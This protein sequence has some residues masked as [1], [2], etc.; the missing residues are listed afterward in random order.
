MGYKII[1]TTDV[2]GNLFSRSFVDGKP[3]PYGAARLST[4][5]QSRRAQ[6]EVVYVDNG[7][8][9]QGT[10]L[11]SF[12]NKNLETA[13][14]AQLWNYLQ[15]DAYNLGNHDFNY[16]PNFLARF[17][18]ACKMPGVCCNVRYKSQALGAPIVK[19]LG[20]KKIGFIGVVTDYI[21]HWEQP[22]NLLDLEVMPVLS[23]VREQVDKLKEQVDHIVVMYHGGLEADPD[24]GNPTE[25]LTGENV[26][27]QLCKEFPEIDLLISG[28]QHRS[29]VAQ[30]GNTV[31]TQCADKASQCVEIDFDPTVPSGANPFTAELI[32]LADY[33]VD[34]CIE[35]HFEDLWVQTNQWLDTPIGKANW[36]DAKI[37]DIVEAQKQKHP[38]ATF[39]NQVQMAVTGADISACCMFEVMPGW[40]ENLSYR[41]VILNYPF[42]NTLV[43]K[44][45]TGKE[46]LAYMNKIATYWVLKDGK[47]TVADK[48]LYPKR[49]IYNYDL[50]DGVQ[51]T[52]VVTEDASYVENVLYQGQ[53]LQL[54]KKYTLAVN[55]YRAVGGGGFAEFLEM[56]TIYED[57][58]DM[59]EIIIEYI[60]EQTKQGKLL[61]VPEKSNCILRVKQN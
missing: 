18:E 42:P 19:N 53:S 13:V 15:V 33:G 21:D 31:V 32:E 16:G 60:V 20:G 37:V 46:L 58:R 61:S 22:A 41:D 52:L 12:A 17:V 40:S 35:K 27:Y 45:I 25:P 29:L 48:H 10:A 47:I 50:F 55:N 57:T 8:T 43:V 7:D 49:E 14:M 59:A 38:V 44:E 23:T 30:V 2:H 1:A 3:V 36:G 39:I 56:P 9:N 54:D 5:L 26:G 24:T 51:Y 11:L 28:H 4:Y 34:D 6:H